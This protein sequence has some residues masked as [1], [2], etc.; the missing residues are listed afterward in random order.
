[1]VRLN[2]TSVFR[3]SC[4]ICTLFALSSIGSFAASS[5]EV[6]RETNHGVS[7]PVSGMPY[8]PLAV[9]M[10]RPRLSI[11][12]ATEPVD[13]EQEDPVLQET[14]GPLVNTTPGLNVLG[15]G[16]G[17]P[18]FTVQFAPP[19]TN[20]AVGATQVVE[21]VNLSLAVFDKTTGTAVAGPIS[22]NNLWNGFD[23]SCSNGSN[24]S[25]PV[26]LYDQLSRR[27]VIEIITVSSPFKFCWAVSTTSDAT[28]SYHVYAFVDSAGLPDYSKIGI[29]SDAYY[30]SGRQ[31]NASLTAFLGPIACAADRATMI[32]GAT[33]TMI[34]FQINNTSV[35]GMLPSSLDGSTA[36]PAGEPNFFMLIPLPDSGTSTKLQMFKFHVDF[37]VPSNSTFTGPTVI[38]VPS[39]TEAGSFGGFVPQG[40]TTNKVDGLGYTLMHRMAYRNFTGTSPHESLVLTHNVNIGVTGRRRYA[41]R[42]YEIR[43]PNTSPV[44]FQS[45]TFSPDTTYR[46]AASIAMDKVGDIALG[47]SASSSTLHPSIRYTGRNAGDAKGTMQAEAI[48]LTGA[49]SQTGGLTRWGDYSSM[50]VDPV[51]DCTMWYSQEYIPSNG[52]FNWSTRL[53]SFKFTAC[54]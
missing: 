53:F 54:Q 46:W 13:A 24:L 30:L 50:A 8:E 28:G 26:V 5:V 43:S 35:D 15:L 4:A 22:I 33:A 34:C 7:A 14:A 16:N 3:R 19:D 42:W 37:T 1:M 40:G 39:Y 44:V 9:H 41:P 2:I 18:G 27:W 23:S 10:M 25:D 32:A 21:V 52:S 12:P 29:W 51:D 36:P 31:F 6:I 47:Y 11:G 45:G 49:G 17:F 20:A 48:I 38:T